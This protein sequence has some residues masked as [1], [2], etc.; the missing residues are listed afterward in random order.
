[1]LKTCKYINV[2][3]RNLYMKIIMSYKCEMNEF[4]TFGKNYFNVER[5]LL[6]FVML[7][8]K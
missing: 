7:L 6:L 8:R 3:I 1:M 2:Y 4:R 5:W